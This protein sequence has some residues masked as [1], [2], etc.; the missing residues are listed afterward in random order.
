[1]THEFSFRNSGDQNLVIRKVS[2]S[3]GCTAAVPSNREVAPGK[4][5]TIR[6]TFSS[7]SMRDKV[8]KQVYV[9][10]NDPSQ[11]RSKLT[12]TGTVKREIDVTPYGIFLRSI[13]VGET[14]EREVQIQPVEAKTFRILEIKS[15]NQAVHVGDPERIDDKRGGYRL[16]IR[17]GPVSQTG[18]TTAVL[19][20]KTDL[21]HTKELHI[22]VYGRVGA[23]SS[24]PAQASR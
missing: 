24:T 12:I 19:T 2:S 1:M 10:S 16:K 3:C 20:V 15:N 17:F 14:V 6:V 13:M 7:G 4:T 18:W 21:T 8:T 22:T 9:E 5:S 23:P 11:P